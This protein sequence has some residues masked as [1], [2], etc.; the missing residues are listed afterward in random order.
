M[1][2]ETDIIRIALI[3]PESTAKSTLSEDL[4]KYYKT[5]WIPEYAR[6]YFKNREN[7][8]N[9]ADNGRYFNRIV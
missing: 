2:Q 7:C 5:I 9:Q 3:G 6:N 8:G 1:A 4:A